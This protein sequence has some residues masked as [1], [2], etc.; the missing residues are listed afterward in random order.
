MITEPRDVE[1]FR[2]LHKMRE[3][4]HT[5]IDSPGTPNPKKH[6]LR[7]DLAAISWAIDTSERQLDVEAA[8]KVREWRMER[9][10]P[11]PGV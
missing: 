7:R 1:K 6:W 8:Q 10:S 3:H 11:R 2:H 5:L 4:L 9:E